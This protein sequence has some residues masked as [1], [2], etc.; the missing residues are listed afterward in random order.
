M[1]KPMGP[2]GQLLE[3]TRRERQLS[4]KDAAAELSVSRQT[5]CSWA[6]EGA[7]PR[8]A[9][10][11]DIA[12]W[13]LQPVE[14]I[15]ALVRTSSTVESPKDAT[16]EQ[17]YRSGDLESANA[18]LEREIAVLSSRDDLRTLV[19]TMLLRARVLKSLGDSKQGVDQA[20]SALEMCEAAGDAGLIPS[21]WCHLE[22]VRV[23]ESS[24]DAATIDVH[25]AAAEHACRQARNRRGLGLT[26]LE[27]GRVEKRRG[28]LD[29]AHDFFTKAARLLKADGDRHDLAIT[30]TDIGRLLRE[31]GR[32][33]AARAA[34]RRSIELADDTMTKGN[35]HQGLGEVERIS[36][37]PEKAIDPLADALRLHQ[38]TRNRLNM[39]ATLFDLGRA[40]REL[41]RYEH[42]KRHQRQA[43]AHFQALGDVR[44]QAN[45]LDALA[46]IARDEEAFEQS[47]RYAG[48]AFSLHLLARNDL[49]IGVSL[50]ILGERAGQ[51][52]E[53]ETSRALLSEAVRR[54]DAAGHVLN[55][56]IAKSNLALT[57]AWLGEREQVRQLVQEAMD[58]L[59]SVGDAAGD[60]E[61]RVTAL[62]NRKSTILGAAQAADLIGD[63]ATAARLRK[64]VDE[65]SPH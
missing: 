13:T 5:Y 63:S 10:W 8:R 49:G 33:R 24:L 61:Q 54:L 25:L 30:Y 31:V 17:L 21:A 1:R 57:L 16:G 64:E 45:V 44:G 42:A 56:A 7:L 46:G 52:Q 14:H 4:Q 39:A 2:L 34:F 29:S 3:R 23:G 62:A 47:L 50:T 28:H 40:E 53:F 26:M 32:Y 58:Q 15:E 37:R 48:E 55:S 27:R 43:M 18:A 38:R 20:T 19:R 59:L 9:S 22:L 41:K 6:F 35:A 11:D 51:L 60:S 65:L 36:G 12:T